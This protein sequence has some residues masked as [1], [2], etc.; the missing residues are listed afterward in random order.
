MLE[1]KVA[2]YI[3]KYVSD[4]GLWIRKARRKDGSF[5]VTNYAET[6]Q[7]YFTIY[8]SLSALG[9]EKKWLGVI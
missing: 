3:K 4:N 1:A 6:T 5:R 8:K 7:V 2:E 9:F